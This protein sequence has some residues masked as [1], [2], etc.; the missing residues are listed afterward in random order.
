M[1]QRQP[2]AGRAGGQGQLLGLDGKGA[3]GSEALLSQPGPPSWASTCSSSLAL[4]SME[5]PW[6]FTEAQHHVASLHSP[7]GSQ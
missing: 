5:P 3:W 1:K 2:G 4:H 7:S 6:T